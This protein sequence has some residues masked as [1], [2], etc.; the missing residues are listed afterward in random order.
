MRTLTSDFN[1][2]LPEV[3][4]NYIHRIGRT[5]RADKT[6]I[7]ISF[8]TEREREQR[9]AV[10]H[11]MKYPIPVVP[12][13]DSLVISDELTDD[14]QPKI[15]MKIV[16]PKMPNRENVGPAFHEKALKNQKVN[17]RRD[18]AAEKMLKYG[19]PIKRSGKK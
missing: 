5:G 13:P 6:G 14:E 3:P 15:H 8:V 1:F 9:T 19:R 16:E 11:L 10:E 7:A 4:E 17:V 2:D 12:L 18:H